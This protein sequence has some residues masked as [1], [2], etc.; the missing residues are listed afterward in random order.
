MYEILSMMLFSL[1]RFMKQYP[2][3]LSVIVRPSASLVLAISISFGRPYET[4]YNN[5]IGN[6]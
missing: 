5:N 6:V 4:K 2:D 3:P 1:M